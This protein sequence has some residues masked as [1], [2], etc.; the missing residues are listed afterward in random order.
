M[1]K[2]KRSGEKIFLKELYKLNEF[3]F[4]TIVIWSRK[5]WLDFKKCTCQ[6]LAETLKKLFFQDYFFV[7]VRNSA[8]KMV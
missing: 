7:L 8:I 5:E 4:I 2:I 1:D 6:I 3:L